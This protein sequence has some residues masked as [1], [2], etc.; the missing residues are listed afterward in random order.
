MVPLPRAKPSKERFE[1]RLDPMRRDEVG[2]PAGR[3]AAEEG[4]EDEGVEADEGER[5]GGKW[6]ALG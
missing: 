5:E 4:E 3:A 6:G 1:S 2:Y